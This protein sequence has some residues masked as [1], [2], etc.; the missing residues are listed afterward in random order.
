MIDPA[1]LLRAHMPDVEVRGVGV[2]YGPDG[3][4]K[5]SPDFDLNSLPPDV[6]RQVESFHAQ[7]F[8]QCPR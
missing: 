1:S 3:K 2:T 6:R 8:L 5:I 4:P 7:E